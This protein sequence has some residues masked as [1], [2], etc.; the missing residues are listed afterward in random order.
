MIFSWR[1]LFTIFCLAL[2]LALCPASLAQCHDDAVE[3]KDESDNK[4][5]VFYVS[6]KRTIEAT[7]NFRCES[8]QNLTPSHP[9]PLTFTVDK[10]YQHYEILRFRQTDSGQR[11]Q[12]GQ[13]HFFFV[14]GAPS[15]LP[16]SNFIY[17]LPYAASVHCRIGQSYFGTFSHQAGTADQYAVDISM[18]EGT[19]ILAARGGKIIAYRDDSNQGGISPDYKQCCNYINVKHDDGT[20]AA[21]VH[22]K[23]KGVA[24]QLGQQV[25]AGTLLGYSGATGWVTNPH[26]HFMVYRINAPAALQTLPFR[27][28]TPL[29]VVP[30]LLSGQTY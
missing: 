29:G 17:S 4:G 9:L 30:Q 23:Y 22:L 5:V 28:R 8:L 6:S 21:Y 20:Y 25:A 14:M 3:I 26:L 11:W 18:P 15:T 12:W 2:T 1:H 7:V 24:V 27:M 19:P 16:T 10:T 13:Y